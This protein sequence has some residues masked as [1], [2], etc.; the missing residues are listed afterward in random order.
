MQGAPTAPVCRG[1]IRGASGWG[2]KGATAEG[3]EGAEGGR[4]LGKG[5]PRRL[6]PALGSGLR[7]N[8]E[9]EPSPRRPARPQGS[10][11]VSEYG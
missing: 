2:P 9:R 10:G 3:V 6:G 5:T 8:D 11:P 1:C 4:G 7:R